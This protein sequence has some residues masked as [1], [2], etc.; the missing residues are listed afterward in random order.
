M[1]CALNIDIEII[2]LLSQ[3]TIAV[4]TTRSID[5]KSDAR[6]IASNLIPGKTYNDEIF[7][8]RRTTLHLRPECRLMSPFLLRKKLRKNADRIPIRT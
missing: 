3:S 1:C 7:K 2:L 5:I 6:D 4:I 8:V